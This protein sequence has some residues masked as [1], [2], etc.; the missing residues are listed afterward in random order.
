MLKENEA[1]LNKSWTVGLQM[2]ISPSLFSV[3]H[4]EIATCFP[5]K[6]KFKILKPACLNITKTYT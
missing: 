1:K 4:L 5:I 3:T 2:Y 6:T